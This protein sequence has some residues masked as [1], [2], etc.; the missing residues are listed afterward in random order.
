MAN[1]GSE[2][3]RA[4]NWRAKDNA[5][6]SRR[7]FERALELMDLTLACAKGYARLKELARVRE[8]W[9]II[10]PAR[11][12][13]GRRKC[14]GGD[15]FCPSLTPRGE[16]PSSPPVLFATIIVIRTVAS[17]AYFNLPATVSQGFSKK[18]RSLQ[19][20]GQEEPD[21]IADDVDQ[22]EIFIDVFE[23]LFVLDQFMQ[24]EQLGW[25][26]RRYRPEGPRPIRLRTPMQ[27]QRG[28]KHPAKQD[29]NG[30]TLDIERA[31]IDVGEEPDHFGEE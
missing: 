12:N 14:H 28:Q 21:E 4:L 20:V 15:T 2:F 1:V 9:R 27:I 23:D 6:Y 10:L 3:E 11:I 30:E 8:A 31:L 25:Q 5:D 26:K 18:P 17:G 24:E 19:P 16:T 22:I 7:A 13:S 29:E